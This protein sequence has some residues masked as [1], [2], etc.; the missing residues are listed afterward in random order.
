MR[1][2]RPLVM[3][4][5][6]VVKYGQIREEVELEKPE[7]SNWR[8]STARR[9]RKRLAS[10]VPSGHLDIEQMVIGEKTSHRTRIGVRAVDTDRDLP[11]FPSSLL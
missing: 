3:H 7:N 6:E 11:A 5:P 2:K 1:G 9:A 8:T 4:P 10:G